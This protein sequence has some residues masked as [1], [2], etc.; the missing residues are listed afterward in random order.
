MIYLLA[1]TIGIVAGLRAVM[2]PAAVS[3]MAARGGLNLSGTW[4]AFLGYRWTP[5]IFTVA[6]IA[7]LVTDQ[8]PSTP[9]RTVPLQ[10]GAR[11]V[12]GGLSGAAIGAPS[13]SWV[14]GLAAGVAGAVIGTMGGA[15][16]RARMAAAFGHDRPAAL[17]E[18][19]VALGG[20]ILVAGLLP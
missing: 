6:A 10:F 11:L 18:D 2:A 5:W 7:E 16:A 9:R 1:L 19:A 14:I 8:L 4:L 17:L 12:F 15:A 13:G 20:A 3:W